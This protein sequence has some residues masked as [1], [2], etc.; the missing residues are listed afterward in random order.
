MIH[1]EVGQYFCRDVTF[2]WG[3]CPEQPL[4]NPTITCQNLPHVKFFF[5][6]VFFRQMPICETI[7]VTGS[8]SWHAFLPVCAVAMD[9]KVKV[10]FAET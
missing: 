1:V 3:L 9:T 7:P 5:S 2:T 8:L 6:I 4:V 10:M